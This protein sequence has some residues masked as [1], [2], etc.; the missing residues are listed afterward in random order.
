MSALLHAFRSVTEEERRLAAIDNM[1]AQLLL[2]EYSDSRTDMVLDA[3]HETSEAVADAIAIHMGHLGHK[4]CAVEKARHYEMIGR[5][6]AGVIDGYCTREAKQA[7]EKVVDRSECP[8][9]FDFGCRHC[10]S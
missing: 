7:A 8:H 3:I 9:C 2:T 6:V 10:T 1:T 4:R 5:L